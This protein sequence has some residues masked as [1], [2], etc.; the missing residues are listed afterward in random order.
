MAVQNTSTSKPGMCTGCG[1]TVPNLGIE[2][3]NLDITIYHGSTG[4]NP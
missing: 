1:Q 4:I 3:S 2:N